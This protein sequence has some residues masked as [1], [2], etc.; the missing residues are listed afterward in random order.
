MD[1]NRQ[2]SSRQLCKRP[3]SSSG[4]PSDHSPPR[5]RRCSFHVFTSARRGSRGAIH[6]G[7]SSSLNL[8][9]SST[10]SILSPASSNSKSTS[11][12]ELK[13]K[14]NEEKPR[15]KKAKLFSNPSKLPFSDEGHLYDLAGRPPEVQLMVLR[16]RRHEFKG[17][18][19]SLKECS[20]EEIEGIKVVLIVRILCHLLCSDGQHLQK[21]KKF[22]YEELT[23][24]SGKELLHALHNSF[25]KMPT[26]KY[27]KRKS[28]SLDLLKDTCHLFE[29]LLNKWP[30]F[31]QH[32]P[33]DALHGAANQ[34]ASQAVRYGEIQQLSQLLVEKRNCIRTEFYSASSCSRQVAETECNNI[35]PTPEELK[36]D[37]L[38]PTLEK[39]K[40][41]G[42]YSS[43][44]DYVECHY[45]LLREDFIRPLR[46]ALHQLQ[47]LEDDENC[48]EVEVYDN[49]CFNHGITSLPVEGILFRISFKFPGQNKVKWERSK[50]FTYGSLVCIF[51]DDFEKV[52]FGTVA[53]RKV[54]DL[55]QGILTIKLQSDDA[56][57]FSPELSF[58]M[59]V[60]PAYYGAY[61]PVLK[62]LEQMKTPD[63][64]QS[65]P[66]S[67]YL[68]ECSSDV[69]PPAY[70]QGKNKVMDLEGIVCE[71]HSPAMEEE[72]LDHPDHYKVDIF[73]PNAWSALQTPSL[74]PSQKA[75]LHAALTKELA[76]IQGPPG[77]GKTYIGLKIVEALLNNTHQL[78]KQGPIVVVCYT[79]HALDQFLEGIL[80]I[81]NRHKLIK[82]QRIGGRCKSEKVQEYNIQKTV[83]RVCCEQMIY[84]CSP[85]EVCKLQSKVQAIE[86]L[87]WGKFVPYNLKV[88]CSIFSKNTIADLLHYCTDK[89]ECHPSLDI[90]IRREGDI[91]AEWLSPEFKREIEE[92]KDYESGHGTVYD[93]HKDMEDDRCIAGYGEDDDD[94]FLHKALR[95]Q[96]IERFMM[97]L[98]QAD[99]SILAPRQYYTI[100]LSHGVP[101]HMRLELFKGWLLILKTE[102][103][104]DLREKERKQRKYI[105]MRDLFQVQILKEADVIGMTTTGAAMYS[106]VM[107]QIKARTIIVEEAAEVLE[108]H[109]ITTLTQHTQHLVLIGDH[110]QLRPKTTDYFLAR[111]YHLDIS[112]F[113]RLVK[114]GFPSVTLE[115][116]HRMRPQI[117]KV[118]SSC[119]YSGRLKDHKSTLEYEDIRGMSHNMYFVDHREPENY[120]SELKS[121]SNQHEAVFL[122]C[123]CLYLFQQGYKPEE[124]TVITPYIGQVFKLQDAFR[125][126]RIFNVRITPIDSYQGEENEII[127]L[128]LVRS[129]EKKK[130][131]FVKESNRVCVALSRAKC[132]FYCIGNFHLLAE[133]SKLWHSIVH[134]LDRCLIGTSL[135][136]KCS[137]HGTITN[138]SSASDFDKVADGGCDK[139]CGARLPCNHI[140]PRKCHPNIDEV[141]KQPCMKPCPKYCKTQ[142]H[143]CKNLCY[144]ECGDCEELVEKIIPKCGH[145]QQVPCHQ[146][147]SKFECQRAC[148]K[149][150]QCGHT[151][152]K[153]CGQLCVKECQILVTREWPC[154][155]T[156]QAEC[157]V[158]KEN[159]SLLRKCKAKCDET[160]ECGHK[161]TGTCG[162]CYQGRLHKR[163]SDKCERPL[164]CGH[165]CSEKCAQNCP[166]CP[167]ECIFTCAHGRC[168]NKCSTLCKPCPEKCEWKCEHHECTKNCGEICNRPRCNEP[169]RRII[170]KCLH[171]CPGLC[172]EQ[173]P[174]DREG[175]R[176]CRICDEEKWSE[177]CQEIFGTEE[178][179]GARFIQLVDCG[180]I[181]EVT[182]LDRWMDMDPSDE[183]AIQWKT[184][185]IC[186]QPIISTLRYSN[187]AKQTLTH[188]N[189]AKKLQCFSMT[190]DERK[191]LEEDID[192]TAHEHVSMFFLNC[193]ER[194]IQYKKQIRELPD[195]SLKQ[196]HVILCAASDAQ[197]ACQLVTVIQSNCNQ[198]E[199]NSDLK[200]K[201]ALLLKQ[202]SSFSRF[203]KII[204]HR[205]TN[206][207]QSDVLAERR[208]LMLL[209]NTY[210]ILCDASATRTPIDPDDLSYLQC[211][212]ERCET[213]GHRIN[214]LDDEGEYLSMQSYLQDLSKKYGVMLTK[215]E[216]KMI[217]AALRAKPG[218]WYKCPKGHIYQIGDC[219]GA[220]QEGKCPECGATI[221]G[222][223]HRLRDDNTHA[224]EFDNS[225]HAA[226]SAGAN[227]A[228]YDPQ[229]ILQ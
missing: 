219:G 225:A 197:K 103:Q 152:T 177:L 145:T 63:L 209:A 18:L 26:E 190:Q 229:D 12:P 124:I 44:A 214:K 36:R 66:F 157:Y 25:C 182:G 161:C 221:G 115:T 24:D 90:L 60:S 34:L 168:G 54:E 119:I 62:R 70:M 129:N 167:K 142:Q 169:C 125:T 191:K 3:F 27:S 133:C 139:N 20:V 109:V 226:W 127:L 122:A 121:P 14:R 148:Q 144:E 1:T 136:L 113:E 80:T 78:G 143:R 116:Q 111:D 10:T 114:N 120:E 7:S 188:I 202:K 64:P 106:S 58:K 96:T 33:V 41:K 38:P 68:V 183:G 107:S 135:P 205:V 222:S 42:C 59:I 141:H 160:L 173:C 118:V 2:S 162:T 85:N 181:F 149:T 79:N 137:S 196:D 185:L 147:P 93:Y 204:S 198:T 49:V 128:S 215:E 100:D 158:T 224:G 84:G 123:F 132:G 48:H 67:R 102:L 134:N 23:A 212:R 37:T 217:I 156:G 17:F 30:D 179:P 83:T 220:T 211:I 227:L 176:I 159:H 71:Y 216:R 199:V 101:L 194:V 56:Y 189:K 6:P 201:V 13:R 19:K 164:L 94:T 112:L 117:S 97:Q 89:F 74:D 40:V 77:T 180:H 72:L 218:S 195:S 165:L 21:C 105:E 8:P 98:Q 166:P 81:N 151:C 5:K 174:V 200:E 51:Q 55:K 4:H 88:F 22:V 47:S 150:L 140:C 223:H 153:K 207:V 75:A 172:G 184:C 50:R 187:I 95:E 16:K 69:H 186:K 91:L 32:L 39:N 31:S 210:K 28:W 104:R 213:V 126:K 155:H 52:V 11:N 46:C 57:S 61:Y 154:G 138:V 65:L 130:T 193:E 82:I 29:A 192:R 99:G 163:C 9:S 131:G 73:D 175:N 15:P 76:I 203:L 45:N 92:F 87:L 146:D 110:E 170:L 53:E 206:Q 35:L 228:N 171:R 208:R 43:T 108:A 86:Q 178:E